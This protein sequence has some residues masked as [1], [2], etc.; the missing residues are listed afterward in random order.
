MKQFTQYYRKYIFGLSER[1]GCP[2]KLIT[3]LGTENV[4]T[5]AMQA[6]L[7]QDID[8]H[9]YVP[10]PRPQRIECCWS[11]LP[12]TR[13]NWWK[14]SFFDLKTEG[15]IDISNFHL[16]LVILVDQICLA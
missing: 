1:N 9:Q 14:H 6:F 4:L 2:I 11:F 10:S 12:N 8:G 5:A 7:Q 16:D 15:V 3:D 13:E